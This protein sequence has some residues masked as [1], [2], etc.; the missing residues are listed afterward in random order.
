MRAVVH[1]AIR[2][3]RMIQP[4]QSVAV[5]C[6]GGS[7]STALLLVLNEQASSLGITLSVAHLNHCLRGKESDGDE[8]FVRALARRLGV[9]C[10]VER[11]DARKIARRSKTNLEAKARELRLQFFESL[12]G[13]RRA[14]VVALGHTADDQA[15]TVLQRL[16]RG[17]GTR[18]LG[19]I[20]PV[21]KSPSNSMLLIR[22]LIRARR[23][24]I[25]DWLT[26]RG[27]NWREDSTNQDILLSRNRIRKDVLPLL[28]GF[29]P[30]VVEALAHTAALARD[31]E[32]F[33]E[34]YLVPIIES[35]VRWK[36]GSA[37]IDL[38]AL[39][40]RPPAVAYRVLRWVVG[41]V[42][43]GCPLGELSQPRSTD[44]QHI[45]QLYDWCLHGQS[46]QRFSLLRGVEARR[47]FSHLIIQRRNGQ[48]LIKP[49]SYCY[50]VH[51]PSMVRV[52]ETGQMF[53]FDFV[54][55][56]E[57]GERYNR[58][59]SIL[60][61]PTLAE[62]PLSLRSWQPGDAFRPEGHR[63]PKKLQDLFQR[64]RI[65]VGERAGWPV[66]WAG[67]QIVWARRF[68]PAAGCS[69]SPDSDLAVEINEI[70]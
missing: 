3:F 58:E 4:G 16:L 40:K 1:E 32:A 35:E 7:D 26:T 18:G 12:I 70:G 42:Q 63:S 17:A 28:E 31:E 48:V 37:T 51:V 56:R 65:P 13:S 67:E 54:A 55:L 50:A 2:E 68:V 24:A 43:Q 22:P 46:G 44:F 14:D 29:N 53:R 62:S 61:T 23:A 66:L 6:S 34:S 9:P 69:A 27:E 45:K 52:T 36:D 5:G 38:L 41:K 19:G 60:L 33:W 30:R 10:F 21:V 15:E 25:R 59:G 20:H 64:A 57:R 49:V 11:V 47:E 8:D 39:G